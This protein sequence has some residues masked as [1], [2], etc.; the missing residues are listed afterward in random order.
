[1]AYRPTSPLGGIRIFYSSSMLLDSDL[2][3]IQVKWILLNL[4][5]GSRDHFHPESILLPMV[6]CCTRRFRSYSP[7]LFWDFVPVAFAIPYHRNIPMDKYIHLPFLL[8]F[9]VDLVITRYPGIPSIVPRIFCAYCLAV[10]CHLNTPTDNFS[11][12]SSIRS[13]PVVHVFHIGLRNTFWS[14]KN[15]Y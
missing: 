5:L 4:T 9:L 15:L 2:S 13:S 3:S 14:S 12:L 8:L 11:P 1:M 10:P 6:D 7:I